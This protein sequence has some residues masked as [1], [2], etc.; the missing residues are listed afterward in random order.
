VFAGLPELFRAE[1]MA[2][3]YAERTRVPADQPALVPGARRCAAAI[4]V[5]FVSLAGV[6]GQAGGHKPM[7]RPDETPGI[8]PVLAELVG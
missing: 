6:R 2:A 3:E 5:R 7:P 1:D 4:H 8:R